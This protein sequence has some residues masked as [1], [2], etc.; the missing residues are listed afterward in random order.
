MISCSLATTYVNFNCTVYR[1]LHHYVFLYTFLAVSLDF[2]TEDFILR[3]HISFPLDLWSACRSTW[4]LKVCP[5]KHVSP[6]GWWYMCVKNGSRWACVASPTWAAGSELGFLGKLL[7]KIRFPELCTVGSCQCLVWRLGKCSTCTASF[8][9]NT[10][11]VML[12]PW[13]Y[14]F[15]EIGSVP[16]NKHEDRWP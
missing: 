5:F 1:P 16:Y 13:A 6:T 11:R 10:F 8:I 14:L 15:C 2:W 3:Y 4:R 7:R 12:L 9:V